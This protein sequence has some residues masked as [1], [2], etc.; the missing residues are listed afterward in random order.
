MIVNFLVNAALIV[1]MGAFAS[2]VTYRIALRIYKSHE[3]NK[4]C[5][6]QKATYSRLHT[7][8]EWTGS[9]TADASLVAEN[10]DSTGGKGNARALSALRKIA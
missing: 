10:S 2:A 7:P 1:S 3:V 6:A 8:Y 5:E 4:S 9:S